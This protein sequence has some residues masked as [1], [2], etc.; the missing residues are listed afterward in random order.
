M[1]RRSRFTFRRARVLNGTPIPQHE[2]AARSLLLTRWGNQGVDQLEKLYREDAY[3]IMDV[4][5]P[6]PWDE[7]RKYVP[8]ITLCLET[9]GTPRT[10][11]ALPSSRRSISDLFGRIEYVW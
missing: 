3:E 10:T 6:I 2:T 11:A 5:P 1:A 4:T 8:A 9:T 7:L